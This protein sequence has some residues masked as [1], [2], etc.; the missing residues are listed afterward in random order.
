M[1]QIK[2]LEMV[3]K[4][5]ESSGVS[6]AVLNYYRHIDHSRIHMDFVVHYDVPRALEEEL[7]Q[8]GAQIYRMP[9]L[10]GWNMLTY[11]RE[12][13]KFFSRHEGEYQIVHGHL[14]NAAL[15]YMKAAKKHGI[16]VRI[17]HSH[18][19]R[20]ADSTAKAIRNFFLNR[21]GVSL[22]TT[23]FA[24]SKPAKRYL[25]GERK[26]RIIHNAIDLDKFTFNPEIRRKLREK[27]N[28]GERVAIG[29]IGRFVHQ[30]NHAYLI[31][32]AGELKKYR[33]D[34]V[35]LLA[36]DGSLRAEIERQIRR[37]H[38]ENFF[39]LTGEVTNP[40]DIYQMLDACVMPSF[41]EGLPVVSV[42][43]QA[44]GLPCLLADTITDEA[45]LTDRIVRLPLK[46]PEA[47]IEELRNLK[48]REKWDDARQRYDCVSRIRE[49]GF[50]IRTEAGKLEDEYISLAEEA[51]D[52][53]FFTVI[54]EIEK[55]E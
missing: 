16:R 41:Y 45:M 23:Y 44:M 10:V 1:E 27:Y 19:S 34:F 13:D 17:L 53:Q 11:V 2:V 6:A 36:G 48:I 9:S 38:L 43:A 25:F 49:K 24:C 5:S 55:T 21:K 7:R 20:G 28:I 26:A 37:K 30:K 40:E 54:R 18:N 39:I 46:K 8:S 33:Q 50:D 4:F 15:F 51:Y 35:F 12:L 29:H 3:E 14:P 47:W 32:L 22:S 31:T 42:E 52:D